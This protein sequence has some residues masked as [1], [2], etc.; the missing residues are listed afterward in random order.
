MEQ[1]S[2]G[3]GIRGEYKWVG[4]MGV[5]KDVRATYNRFIFVPGATHVI[6]FELFELCTLG[7][8]CENN[9]GHG[10]PSPGYGTNWDMAQCDCH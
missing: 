9:L 2:N 10:D 3:G 7:F 1:H 5:Y 4:M 6:W 8:R